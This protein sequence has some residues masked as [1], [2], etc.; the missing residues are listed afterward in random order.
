MDVS[1]GVVQRMDALKNR[2]LALSEAEGLRGLLYP[3]LPGKLKF[4]DLDA[5]AARQAGKM[6]VQ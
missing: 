1:D 6:L 5:L 3:D 2:N 4:G